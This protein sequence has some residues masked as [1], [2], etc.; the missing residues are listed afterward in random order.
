MKFTKM[1]GTGNDFIVIEDLDEEL[2]EKESELSKK[3]CHRRFGI[4]GDGVLVVRKSNIADVKMEIINSDGSYAEMC[5]NGIR[6]FARYV[7]DKS[8]IKK[9][10]INIETGD[11]VKIAYLQLEDNQVVGI[12]INMGKYSLEPKNIPVKSE[13]KVINKDI[14]INKNEYK[15][16]SMF[17][18]VPHTVIMCKLEE[19]D[20]EEGKFIEQCDFFEQG[21]NVNFCEVVD[22][23]TIKVKTWER[24][25]GPTLACGTGSCSCVIAC[26]LFGYTNSSVRVI[27]PGGELKIQYLPEKVFMTGPAEIVYEGEILI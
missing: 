6:C 9:D 20:I 21:T 27:V 8:I 19:H 4:G 24:G 25:A 10:I 14:I 13:E 16:T 5:G 22:K 26:N 7:Y 17:M 12:K 3:L 18:G 2:K 15:I 1:H 11:G 23:N